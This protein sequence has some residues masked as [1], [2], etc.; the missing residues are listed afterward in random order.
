MEKSYEPSRSMD[1]DTHDSGRHRAQIRISG[2]GFRPAHELCLHR[3]GR[4]R[5]NDLAVGPQR[6][7]AGRHLENRGTPFHGQSL[8]GTPDIGGDLHH[9]GNSLQ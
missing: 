2:H 8:V 1:L 9:G 4:H 6:I 7:R 3:T 5:R